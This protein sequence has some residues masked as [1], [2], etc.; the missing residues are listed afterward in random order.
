MK[1]LYSI[2]RFRV[3]NKI[4]NMNIENR[5]RPTCFHANGSGRRFSP[6]AAYTSANNWFLARSKSPRPRQY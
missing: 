3:K 4:P 6:N 1:K 5:L 2:N